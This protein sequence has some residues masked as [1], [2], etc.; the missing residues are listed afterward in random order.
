LYEYVMLRWP[1]LGAVL[2]RGS[3]LNLSSWM[4][5][6]GSN[7]AGCL[8]FFPL[9]LPLGSLP[10]AS[11]RVASADEQSDVAGGARQA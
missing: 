8:P 3:F 7:A 2:V 1:V 10:P 6:C 11:A 5:A 4:L 9:P